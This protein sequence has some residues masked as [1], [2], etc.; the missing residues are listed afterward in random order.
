MSKIKANTEVVL[1]GR[2]PLTLRPNDHIATGGEG[3]I[4]KA[5]DT[6]IKIYTDPQKV[7]WNDIEEKLKFFHSN[8]HPYIVAPQ[9]RVTMPSGKT[10][11]YFMKY[12]QGEPIARV[13]TN[14]FRQRTN[15]NDQNASLLV[16]RM[17]EILMFAHSCNALLI[18]ANELGYFVIMSQSKQPEPRIIDVDCWVIGNNW[19]PTVPIMPSIRDWHTKKWNNGTDWFAWGVVTFQVYTGIHPY[20]GTLDGFQRNDLEGRMKANASVFTQGIRLNRAVRDFSIIPGP[21]LDWYVATFQNT[22]R[23]IPPSPFETGIVTARIARVMR[24]VTT[25]SGMLVFDK[26]Y[27]KADDRAIRIFPCGVVLLNSDKL[28]NLSNKREIGVAK[29]HDCELVRAQN[30]WLKADMNDRNIKFSH[31]NE[32]SL[33]EQLL[34]LNI[35]GHKLIRYENRLF[36]VTDKGLTEVVLKILGNKPILSVGQTWGV[37]INSTRWFNGMGIQ[38]TMGATYVIAPFGD[39]SCAQIR[40]RELDSLKLVMAKAGHRFITVIGLDHNGVYQKIE[41]TFNREYNN[42][43]AWQGATDSPDLNIAILPKGVCAAIVNDGE[44]DIFVPTTGAFNKVQDKLISTDMTLANLD[45]KVV[46]IQD[47]D[48]W[49][50]RM[51]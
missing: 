34:T 35:K 7:I 10:I 39:N 1:D 51:K 40:A 9:G 31:I 6:A 24:V 26:L 41:L 5:G 43:K 48:V 33:N 38:D 49:S 28:V 22:E 3:S 25:A 2:G 17:R 18:D 21:L 23:T 44:L 15:F 4:F 46:Y 19:P 29:S 47:G 36:V 50:V 45:N 27:S 37:M 12:V 20:K 13:F 11:G 42:Y 14:D 16:E 32:T 8:Q 30:G